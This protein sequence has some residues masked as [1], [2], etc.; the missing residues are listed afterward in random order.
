MV[1]PLKTSP[2]TAKQVVVVGQLT[3]LKSK[4]L[5]GERWEFQVPPPSVV[6]TMDPPVLTAKQVVDV[7]QLIPL[8]KPVPKDR[9]FQVPPPSVV[10][11]TVSPVPTAKQ[12][13]DVGQ[14]TPS[15]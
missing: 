6:A 12:V 4:E 13:V 3:S 1:S 11:R 8:R 2:P 14:L 7:G 10:L 9:R 15:R 5:S